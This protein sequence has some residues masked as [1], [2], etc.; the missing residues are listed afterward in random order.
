[1][2]LF[3]RIGPILIASDELLI[4]GS[5]SIKSPSYTAGPATS[6]LSVSY[7]R[8]AVTPYQMII[9]LRLTMANKEARIHMH[10]GR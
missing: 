5:L 6:D 4:K 8:Y 7:H 1:M 10:V 3:L 9:A 2:R